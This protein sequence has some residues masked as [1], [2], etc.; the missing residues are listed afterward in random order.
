MRRQGRR[1]VV[2][3]VG[4]ACLFSASC[5]GSADVVT[6]TSTETSTNTITYG[7]VPDLTLVAMD[8]S[9]L[10]VVGTLDARCHPQVAA[11]GASYTKEE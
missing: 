9:R 8:G 10:I 2:G 3:F 7:R 1:V 4:L 5:G 6:E 11:L